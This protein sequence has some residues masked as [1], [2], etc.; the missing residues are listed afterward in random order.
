MGAAAGETNMED[1]FARGAAGV[2]GLS[3]VEK[4]AG[5]LRWA[6]T[7]IIYE[8]NQTCLITRSLNSISRFFQGGGTQRGLALAVLALSAWSLLAS[9]TY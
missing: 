3:R 6:R 1:E 8:P 7:G 9:L 2:R 4:A 5:S